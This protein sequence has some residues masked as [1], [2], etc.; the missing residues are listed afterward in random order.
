MSQKWYKCP[1]HTCTGSFAHQFFAHFQAIQYCILLSLKD[2]LSLCPL[3]CV[4]L[5]VLALP[6]PHPPLLEVFQWEGLDKDCVC[7]L[8]N[9]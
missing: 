2:M 9:N 3:V 4:F 6:H 5:L 1:P 7:F 8:I